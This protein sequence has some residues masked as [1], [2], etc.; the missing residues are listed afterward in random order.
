MAIAPE[1]SLFT[2]S[3]FRDWKGQEGRRIEKKGVSAGE[4]DRE[5]GR[6]RDWREGEREEG[7]KEKEDNV[8][9]R[10]YG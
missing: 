9:G 2:L 8:R 10:K 3:L 6:S 1:A 7:G 4:K 5:K